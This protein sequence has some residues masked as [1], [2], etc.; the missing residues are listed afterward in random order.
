MLGLDPKV[1][2]IVVLA[3]VS[4]GAV[5]YALLFSQIEA[6][7]KA[8]GRVRKIKAAETDRVKVKA[9]R[10]RV[11]E[12]GKRRKSIQDTLKT[13]EQKQKEDGRTKA[14]PLKDRLMQAGLAISVRQFYMLSA[15]CAACARP[16]GLP[17]RRAD[18]RRGRR[19]PGRPSWACRAGPS[20]SSRRGG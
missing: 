7:K 9:A 15:A 4:A 19:R 5:G 10:D 12:M 2:A 16:G 6:Q 3:A 17:R 18:L 1:L 8:Q 20:A 14:P 13:L 11:A